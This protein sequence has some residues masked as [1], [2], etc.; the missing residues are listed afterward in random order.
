MGIWQK[1]EQ[2]DIEAI[3]DAIETRNKI[4]KYFKVEV[5]FQDKADTNYGHHSSLNEFTILINKY[6]VEYVI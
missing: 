3:V 2:E 4:D 6:L 5:I 1:N